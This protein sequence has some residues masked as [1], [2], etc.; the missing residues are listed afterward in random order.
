MASKRVLLLGGHGKVSLLLTSHLLGRSWQVTSVIRDSSQTNDILT[1]ANGQPGKVDVLI[2][3]LEEIQ[4]EQDAQQTHPTTFNLAAAK[5]T[6]NGQL[7]AGGK[8]GPSRTVAIDRDSCIHFIRAAANTPSIRKFL[9]VSYLGSRRA[10]APWW[11]E[12]EWRATQQ[13]NS[14]V[15][16]N[17]YPAKLAADECLTAVASTRGDEFKA[18][19]LRPGSLTDEES[20]GRIS[21]GKT[22][23]R[24]SISRG[25]VAA[26]AAKLLETDASGWLD[27]LEGEEDSG[28]AVDRVIRDGVD[29]KEGEDVDLMEKMYLK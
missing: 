21:L 28:E 8:G 15:L 3:S 2:R 11:S 27:L 18:I 24:G 22:K 10:K 7:G 12:E 20:V 9:L 17:Y 4:S 23:A 25:D 16:K 13:V 26:V 14:G 1:K 19:I 6:P 29:C 5:A